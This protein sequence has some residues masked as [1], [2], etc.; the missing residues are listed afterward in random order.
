MQI[1]AILYLCV[2]TIIAYWSFAECLRHIDA[3]LAAVLVT[4]GPVITFALLL[5]TNRMDQARIPY[6]PFTLARLAG[7]ALVMGGVALAVWRPKLGPSVR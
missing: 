1:A 3:S 4:I 6:E 5:V 2:N 7:A